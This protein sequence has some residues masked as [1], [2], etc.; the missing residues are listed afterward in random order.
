M[1]HAD[2]KD[3][4]SR[5][6]EYSRQLACRREV[7][8]Q[9]A[10]VGEDLKAGVEAGTPSS[11]AEILDRRRSVLQ[12]LEQVLAQ[13]KDVD[14]MVEKTSQLTNQ[15]Y[16]EAPEAANEILAS[17][18][19]MAEAAKGILRNQ[20]EC[21][22]ILRN[23][24]GIVRKQRRQITRTRNINSAYNGRVYNDPRFLDSSR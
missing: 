17:A 21:E 20:K 24:L 14:K 3:L 23:S 6:E 5:F 2:V 10:E 12:R 9:L 11:L 18:G 13:T 16:A 22:E 7:L 1:I 4:V 15:Q 8:A 19:E